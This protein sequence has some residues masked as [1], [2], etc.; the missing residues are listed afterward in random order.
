MVV[1]ST[2][3]REKQEGIGLAG[4]HTNEEEGG[5][6]D[7]R[8]VFPETRELKVC[9]IKHDCVVHSDSLS[10]TVRYPQIAL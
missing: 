8:G 5:D 9:S 6:E 3:M 10:L 2:S 1:V 4:P 7:G